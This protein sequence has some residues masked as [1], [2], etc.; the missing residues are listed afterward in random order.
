MKDKLENCPF[1]GSKHVSIVTYDYISPKYELICDSC[2]MAVADYDK[3]EL[4]KKWNNRTYINKLKDKI[5]EFKKQ[6]NI[7]E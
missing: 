6:L 4:I 7:N 3:Q 2:G 1:C 5:K